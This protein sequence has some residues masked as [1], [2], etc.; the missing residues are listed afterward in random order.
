MSGLQ[1]CQFCGKDYTDYNPYFIW[2]H[3]TI[4]CEK[5]PNKD[6]NFIA[7]FKENERERMRLY[8]Q[9]NREKEIERKRIYR[10]EHKE[11]I[12]ERERKHYQENKDKF[13]QYREDNKEK[14]KEKDKR[15]YEAHKDEIKKKKS[16]KVICEC[17]KEITK[18]HI[19]EHRKTKIHQ[20]LLD[21]LNTQ[22]EA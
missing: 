17:G 10:E 19:A 13:K 14:L 5:N 8:Y 7:E 21:A 4:Q 1:Q 9:Q 18:H 11:E 22:E 6:H 12:R 16:T 2:K 15:Y 20:K 3:Q